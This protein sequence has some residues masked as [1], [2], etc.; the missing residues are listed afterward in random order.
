MQWLELVKK[1]PS[2]YSLWLVDFSSRSLDLRSCWYLRLSPAS[3]PGWWWPSG[4]TPTKE[5]LFLVCWLASLL[6][7][8]PETGQ[9]LLTQLSISN[10][11]FYHV[12]FFILTNIFIVI[13]LMLP[14]MPIGAHWRCFRWGLFWWLEFYLYY[15]HLL[16]QLAA[17]NIG[18][19]IVF[20]GMLIHY[21]VSIMS[22]VFMIFP[23]LGFFL[24]FISRDSPIF[25]ERLVT[26]LVRPWK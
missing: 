1:Y 15:L 24:M 21:D 20:V 7:S 16:F 25:V 9:C 23:V 6:V 18:G 12:F 5:L 11:L 14:A 19:I 10:F 4:L 2:S 3:S 17:K 26:I 13:S 8:S 22:F